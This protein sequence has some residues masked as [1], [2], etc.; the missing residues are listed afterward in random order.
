MIRSRLDV[1]V[2]TP[3]GYELVDYKTD[4]VTPERLAS[5]INFYREQMDLYREAITSVLS[6]PPTAIHLAFLTPRL[7]HTF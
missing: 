5:R 6:H 4:N 7:I 1:L 2:P 3:R